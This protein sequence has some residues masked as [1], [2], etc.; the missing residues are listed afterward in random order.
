[1]LQRAHSLALSLSLSP[2]GPAS[3]L[4]PRL[5][6]FY[7][8]TRASACTVA[9]SLSSSVYPSARSTPSLPVSFPGDS[10][11]TIFT[12]FKPF[13]SGP[14]CRNPLLP[15]FTTVF[16]N[17]APERIEFLGFN[18]CSLREDNPLSSY[19][20]LCQDTLGMR[21]SA[22]RLMNFLSSLGAMG[23]GVEC[24]EKSTNSR[25]VNVK[26]RWRIYD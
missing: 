23:I 13:R 15:R 17:S 9:I 10:L 8:Y 19:L 2:L 11:S 22:G 5:F 14:L 18:T 26:T 12:A 25:I 20:Y 21:G 3:S 6:R 16:R 1:M 4:G 24:F 7:T